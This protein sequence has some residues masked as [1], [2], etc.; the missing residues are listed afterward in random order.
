MQGDSWR[1]NY[2]KIFVRYCFASFLF[3]D[4]LETGNPLGSHDRVNK[5]GA[6]YASIYLESEGIFIKVDDILRRVKFQLVDIR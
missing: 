6:A 3:Y 2:F 4:D 5:F 1:E